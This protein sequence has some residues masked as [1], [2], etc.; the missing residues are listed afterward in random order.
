V[1]RFLADRARGCIC[2]PEVPV[3]VCGREPEAELL[4]R[5]AIAPGP[6]EVERNPRAS[7][8]HLRAVRKIREADK[9]G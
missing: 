8:A 4:N 3:C 7:A 5:K 9:D 2:P 1:K 6:E